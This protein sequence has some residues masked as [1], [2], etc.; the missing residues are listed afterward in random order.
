MLLGLVSSL[1]D[2][3]WILIVYK[4]GAEDKIDVKSLNINLKKGIGL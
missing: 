4:E 1:L 2:Q 3:Q